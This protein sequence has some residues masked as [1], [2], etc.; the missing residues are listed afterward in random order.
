M[1]ASS[2]VLARTVLEQM[3]KGVPAEHNGQTKMAQA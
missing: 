1:M 3:E 2:T